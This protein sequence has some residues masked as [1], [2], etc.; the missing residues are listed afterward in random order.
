M[1]VCIAET[2]A[3]DSQSLKLMAVIDDVGRYYQIGCAESDCDMYTLSV[4][5]DA[6]S[7]LLQ[8]VTRS[9]MVVFWHSGSVLVSISVV[10]CVGPS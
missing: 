3:S 9:L 4:T 10:T 6:A 1:S 5:I 2:G 8:V 7:G